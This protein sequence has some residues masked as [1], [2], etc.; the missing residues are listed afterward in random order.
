[1]AL[2]SWNFSRKMRLQYSHL[3][4]GAIGRLKVCS[5]QVNVKS[6]E[7]EEKSLEKVSCQKSFMYAHFLNTGMN[8]PPLLETIFCFL[9]NRKANTDLFDISNMCTLHVLYKCQQKGQIY[10]YL[11]SMT[12]VS[13]C[14]VQSKAL[15]LISACLALFSPPVFDEIRLASSVPLLRYNASIFT[16]VLTRFIIGITEISSFCKEF[17]SLLSCSGLFSS[18]VCSI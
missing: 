17:S 15:T 1:M 5:R 2:V 10:V 14:C 11:R 12:C 4:L 6:V 9:L 8:K 16:K 18:L 13:Q 3:L 7:G